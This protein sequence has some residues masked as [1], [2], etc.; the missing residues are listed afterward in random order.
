MGTGP[1]FERGDA[2]RWAAG[3]L[4]DLE[5]L[6]AAVAA[7]SRAARERLEA[8]RVARRDE[9]IR[10]RL[11]E[12]DVATLAERGRRVP[13]KALERAGVRSAADVLRYG[14]H[15][16]DALD[17]I[18]A[19]SA[20]QLVELA[21]AEAGPR[22]KDLRP[23]ADPATWTRADLELVKALR[24]A[25]TV[26]ALLDRADVGALR[27]LADL[28][29]LDRRATRWLTWAASPPG[30]R[31]RTRAGHE[32]AT[33]GW[34]AARA[35]FDRL[36]G[37]RDRVEH[38]LRSPVTDGAAVTAWRTGSADLLAWLERYV[39]EHGS[40]AERSGARH[41]G[42]GLPADLVAAIRAFPLDRSLVRKTLRD[43]QS[44]G[45]GFALTVGRALLGDEMGLGK[46]VQALAAVAHATAADREPHHL[47]ICPA[48]LID[49]WLREI[50]E[51]VPDIPGYAFRGDERADSL[52]RWQRAGGILVASYNLA[53]RLVTADLP[54]LGYL[55]ADEA[56]WV[57]NPD[58]KR[59][60]A[61][62]ALAP[63]ASRVLLMSGT[64]ME[65]RATELIDV[66]GIADPAV[67][68]GL[69]TSFD[70]GES[71]PLRAPE[72]RQAIGRVYL[73]RNQTEVLDELPDI[74]L[75]D[76]PVVVGAAEMSVY[77][78]A[79]GAG[80]LMAARRA[81]AS[82]AGTGSVKMRVLA[83]IVEESR[84]D[85]LKVL[86]FSY[87][88]D[89]LTAAAAVAGCEQIT[90]GLTPAER[91]RRLDTLR[92]ADG[93]AALAL[94]FDVGGQ[95][96]NLQQA[97]VV[98]LMEPQY[99]PTT[100]WQAI[101]RAHRMGQTRSISVFRL[102]AQGTVETRIIELTAVKERHFNDLARRSTLADDDATRLDTPVDD[103]RLLADEQRRLGLPPT[104]A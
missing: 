80:N 73:R 14:Q 68:G 52:R 53:D 8:A 61:T 82:G 3:L 40:A 96:L 2:H 32:Q 41:R 71:A 103:R 31:A 27:Q 15:G 63:R 1:A 81:L 18:G 101:R 104:A 9:S 51:T 84:A 58:A 33:A 72:F 16:L 69:R 66:V 43:Y 75:T 35:G 60:R 89:V 39:G 56:H 23:P 91:E 36:A 10:R 100:E 65:N 67:A 29:R 54:V 74:V 47:V 79:I 19:A 28:L 30:R 49:N 88:R 12:V 90:G 45:A 83:D 93:Y 25:A 4:A 50:D 78:D 76:Q 17:G 24:V 13:R 57:K 38:A 92:D 85:G 62:A 98:V 48:A 44:F 86:V 102:Y 21:R 77:R 46:T 6:L 26:G 97:S 42:S 59:T 20:A 55:V 37:D 22:P 64:P 34:R 7:A 95:G 94:Q 70:G 11:A 87:F 99:K 5:P